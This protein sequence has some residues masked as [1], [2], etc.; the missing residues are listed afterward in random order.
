M[1]AIVVLVAE[2]GERH[3]PTQRLSQTIETAPKRQLEKEPMESEEPSEPFWTWFIE[4]PRQHA[5]R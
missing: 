5:A 1:Q 4:N 3:P 2:T